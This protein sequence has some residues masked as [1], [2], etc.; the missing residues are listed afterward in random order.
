[1]TN[2]DS[3]KLIDDDP[4][5]ADLATSEKKWA[6]LVVDDEEEIHVVTSLA[7][8]GFE[9][10]GHGLEII[11]AY[12]A[13]EAKQIMSEREDIAMILLDVV[14]ET[15]TAGLEVVEYIRNTLRNKF[16]RIV[17]RTGQPG[18]APEYRVITSYDIND[19]K[20]KTELTR[21]KLFTCVYTSLSSYRDLVALDMHRQGLI[22][23]IEATAELYNCQ[24]INEFTQGVIEQVSALLYLEQDLIVVRAS[25]L[26]LETSNN[27]LEVVAATGKFQPLSE[28]HNIDT[29]DPEVKT[30]INNSLLSQHNCHGENY[31]VAFYTTDSEVKHILYVAGEAPISTPDMS[32]VDL[33]AKNVALAHENLLRML[34]NATT[35]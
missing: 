10:A 22:K 24:S 12:S 34:N 2:E 8:Q 29:I 1:M 28:N 32:L 14:M 4:N 5:E 9:F 16:T 27:R 25:G 21:Q 6:L 30:R 18:Q 15:E 35:H 31:Y 7:L 33:F 19:Y 26:A 13:Q 17:L 3:L 11:S 20:E 23:V